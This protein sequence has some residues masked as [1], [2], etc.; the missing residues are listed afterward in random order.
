MKLPRN[1]SSRDL[2]RALCALDYGVTRQRG[3]HARLIT[4]RDGEH[5]VTI[6]AHDPI[7]VGTLS[8]ILKSVAAH[9]NLAPDELLRLLEL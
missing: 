3:S 4:Q 1:V 8:A 2:I 6:P 7:K 9:H 5:H